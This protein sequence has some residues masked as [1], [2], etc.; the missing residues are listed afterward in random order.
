MKIYQ[1][2]KF[3]L[4]NF[5]AQ[6]KWN[7]ITFL[8]RFVP[9]VASLFI[10]FPPFSHWFLFFI[11]KATVIMFLMLSVLGTLGFFFIAVFVS[12]LKQRT[13][14]TFNTMNQPFLLS[15]VFAALTYGLWTFYDFDWYMLKLG[16]FLFVFGLI[17]TIVFQISIAYKVKHAKEAEESPEPTITIDITEDS[18]L[19]E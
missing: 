12:K 18:K 7:R 1:D 10:V 8:I 19:E 15:L 6:R 16:Q 4:P 17:S 13:K 3:F 5:K 11:S 2:G 14:G 9:A